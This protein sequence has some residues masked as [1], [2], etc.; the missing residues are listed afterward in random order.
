MTTAYPPTVHH[1]STRVDPSTALSLLQSYLDESSRSAYL[2]PDALLTEL[3]PQLSGSSE[4]GGLTLHHLRRVEAGLRGERLG[5][6]EFEGIGTVEL[7]DQAVK[8]TQAGEGEGSKDLAWV[9]MEV[10]ERAQE[11]EQGELGDRGTAG[12]VEGGE[13][14]TLQSTGDPTMSRKEAKRLRRKEEQRVKA[15]ERKRANRLKSEEN[16]R[17]RVDESLKLQ[18]LEMK[19]DVDGRWVHLSAR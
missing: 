1:G 2:H 4:E 19:A 8:K 6:V 9:D 12:V 16:L 11:I 14:P 13:V 10:Y 5:D 7:E 18:D 3:G 17:M 15:E